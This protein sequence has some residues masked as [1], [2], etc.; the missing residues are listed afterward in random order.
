M[1][2]LCTGAASRVPAVTRHPD[3]LAGV[4]LDARVD[5]SKASGTPAAAAV[6]Y[7]YPLGSSALIAVVAA[8]LV[9]PFAPA[10]KWLWAIWMERA[11]FSHG[12][13][14]PFIAAFLVWQQ[15]DV[16]ERLEWRGDWWG[17]AAVALGGV[18]LFLGV[19]GATYTLQQYAMVLVVAGLALSLTG[20]A[21]ARRLR[22]PIFVLVLM[23]PQPMFV[24]NNVSE[25]LQIFSSAIGV[26]FIRLFGISVFRE[27]NIIDLGTYKLQV[28]EACDG[29]RYLFPLMAVGLLI[30]YFYKGAF[31]KRALV[32]L[33]SIPVTIFM[34]SLRVG[35]IGVTVDRWGIAMAEGFLHEFQGWMVFMLSGAILIGLTALLNRIGAPSGHWRHVFGLEFPAPTPVDAVVRERTLPFAFKCAAALVALIAGATV[36]LP[37]AAEYSPPREAFAT[38]PVRDGDW[39]G[40]RQAIEPEVLSALQ[41]DDYV[42][43]DY[44]R[45][46]GREV[47]NFYVSYYATQRDRRVVHSPRACIPGGG[48]H[49]DESSVVTIAGTDIRANRMRITNG[50]AHELVYYW[51]DQRGRDL[52]SELSVKWYLFWDSVTRHRSDGSMIRIMTPIGRLEAEAVADARLAAFAKPMLRRID[53]YVP[54]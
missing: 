20:G 17:V 46:A 26:D 18:L 38:Y 40:R 29:L 24:L 34:N 45:D 31:W 6:V 42:L 48:W 52:T 28:V 33:A 9:I 25:K 39:V 44:Q 27:G 43:A 12:P 22:A 23:I 16:L 49:V 36:W 51:F 14:L 8:L 35:V 10:V 41:L 32:F 15:R 30:A 54:R 3:S 5:P 13:I 53:A 19:L 50:D 1:R 4:S 47:V 11:E 21:A 37:S 7:R 2:R